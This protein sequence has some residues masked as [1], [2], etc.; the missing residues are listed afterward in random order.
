MCPEKYQHFVIWSWGMMWKNIGSHFPRKMEEKPRPSYPMPSKLPQF[1]VLIHYTIF[2]YE[3]L[4][5]LQ[6]LR[7]E[8]KIFLTVLKSLFCLVKFWY[9]FQLGSKIWKGYVCKTWKAPFMLLNKV[10]NPF[11]LVICCFLRSEKGFAY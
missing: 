2:L 5:F 6:R 8:I 4:T 3:A 1:T 7:E 10:K 11:F 9:F